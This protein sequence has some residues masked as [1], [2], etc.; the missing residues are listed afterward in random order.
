MPLSSIQ[1]CTVS[2]DKGV[3]QVRHHRIKLFALQG[4]VSHAFN[5]V[6]LSDRGHLI[7]HAFQLRGRGKFVICALRFPALSHHVIINIHATSTW[8]QQV[9]LTIMKSLGLALFTMES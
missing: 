7:H 8:A 6:P 4:E 3:G 1:L 2:E 5:Q 9:A